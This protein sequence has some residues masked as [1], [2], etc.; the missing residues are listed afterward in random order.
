MS[1]HGHEEPH[2]QQAEDEI[3]YGKIV[4]VGVVSL[5][6]FAIA[7]VWAAIILSKQ[8]KHVHEESGEAI[9]PAEIGRSEIGIVDQVPFITDHRLESWRAERA[10]RLNGYGWVDKAKGIAH[11]PIEKALDAVATGA[12][13]AGAPR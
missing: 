13:P 7:T 2:G 5:I 11:V 1:Q 3:Q 6:I 9:R 12:L 10:A 4:K 8:T